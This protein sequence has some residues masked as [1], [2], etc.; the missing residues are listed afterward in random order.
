MATLSHLDERLEGSD[1]S[2]HDQLGFAT[3]TTQFAFYIHRVSRSIVAALIS[4][5]I[6]R[7]QSR[8]SHDDGIPVTSPDE[9]C[10]E[11]I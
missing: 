7:N 2:S 8:Q 10:T 5:L 9:I 6:V 4:E 3:E 1:T 11:G